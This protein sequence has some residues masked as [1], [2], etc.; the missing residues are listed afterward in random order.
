M[1][2]TE[3]ASAARRAQGEESRERLIAAAIETM[4]ER[5]YVAASVGDIC[6]RA[7]V[8]K[9]ALYGHF[10]SKEGL[11]AAVIERVGASW[12]EELQKRVYLVGEPMSRIDSFVDAW[13]DILETH[14]HIIRLPLVVQLGIGENSAS[15]RNALGEVMRRARDAVVQGIEDSLGHGLRDLDMVA[16][17]LLT[18]LRGALLHRVVNPDDEQ[19]RDRVF[20]ELRRTII[21][22]LWDRLPADSK[23]LIP[24]GSPEHDRATH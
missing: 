18:L 3:P 9:T 12:I 19:G 20:Q 4:S 1:R 11:L 14:P 17:T 2:N 8:A 16:E 23:H 5:G 13:R 10:A 7:G 22:V 24:I 15:I 21:V 6:D